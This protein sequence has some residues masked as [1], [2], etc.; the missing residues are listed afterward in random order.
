MFDT[1]EEGSIPVA[2]TVGA[3]T[4]YYRKTRRNTVQKVVYERYLREDIPCGVETCELCKDLSEFK[5][6]SCL[7]Q[8]PALGQYVVIDTNV[9][10]KQIDFLER[11]NGMK[12]VV[13]PITVLKEVKHLDPHTYYRLRAITSDPDRRFYVFSNEFQKKCFIERLPGETPNDR[14]DRGTH[15]LLRH[16]TRFIKASFYCS[17]YSN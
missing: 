11:P 16:K 5:E 1:S 17:V 3:Q 7:S 4:E 12:D 8:K 9:V 15:N 14:N 13:V 10:M 2:I 6:Q